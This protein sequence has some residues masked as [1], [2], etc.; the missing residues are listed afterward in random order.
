MDV[1][2]EEDGATQLA[3]LDKSDPQGTGRGT[4][5]QPHSTGTVGTGV[6]TTLQK[7]SS[8]LIIAEHFCILHMSWE[9][10]TALRSSSR[11]ICRAPL[12]C[13]IAGT[14]QAAAAVPIARF[15]TKR[16]KTHSFQLTHSN[17]GTLIA[18]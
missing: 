9:A 4:A 16:S 18:F 13:L 7:L 8:L 6:K 15:H 2:R 14:R 10:L 12:K 11:L 17:K 3:L 1:A 5:P